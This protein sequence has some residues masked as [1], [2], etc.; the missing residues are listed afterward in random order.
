[1]MNWASQWAVYLYQ[2]LMLWEFVITVSYWAFI[3]EEP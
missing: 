1:M 3:F 2:C